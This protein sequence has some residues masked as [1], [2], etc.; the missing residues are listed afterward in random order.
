MAIIHEIGDVIGG[1][2]PE[3]SIGVIGKCVGI[4]GIIRVTAGR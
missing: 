1:V 2:F 3:K 4:A